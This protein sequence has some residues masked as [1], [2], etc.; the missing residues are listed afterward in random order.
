[1]E[2]I[3]TPKHARMLIQ[4]GN[5]NGEKFAP[6]GQAGGG[7]SPLTEMYIERGGKLKIL[8][9]MVTEPVQMG[10][11][12]ITKCQGGGGWGN[13]LNRDVEKVRNDV[14]N[15]LVSVQRARDVYGVIVDPE[16]FQVDYEGTKKLR[17]EKKAQSA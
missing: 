13:P 10:D 6:F 15:G 12:I 9:T 5:S 3:L 7:S 1:M 14:L 2:E 17:E 16:N 4:S 11:K 8:R